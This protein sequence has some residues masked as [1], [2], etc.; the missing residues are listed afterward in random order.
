MCAKLCPAMQRCQSSSPRINLPW[1]ICNF[2][3]D[4]DHDLECPIEPWI[5][6]QRVRVVFEVVYRRN[7]LT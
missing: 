5:L 1:L 4:G 2:A 3:F 6:R 7:V